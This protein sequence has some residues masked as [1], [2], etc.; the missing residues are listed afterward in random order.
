MTPAEI[1]AVIEMDSALQEL[2]DSGDWVGLSAALP[3][4]VTVSQTLGG[5]GVVLEA[6]GPSVGSGV[7]DALEE[8]S[9]S[10]SAVKWA[11]VLINLGEL[12]FGSEATRGVIN[13]LT[14]AGVFDQVA[15]SAGIS[16]DGIQ[17]SLLAIAET[18]APHRWQYV[19]KAVEG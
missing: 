6:L 5:V 9:I 3:D 8:V 18:S 15:T 16:S 2:R 7:L 17:E 4:Q 12:D 11:F 19:Q 10:N 13:Q 1:R 14:A